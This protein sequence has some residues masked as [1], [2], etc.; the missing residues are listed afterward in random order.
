MC[1]RDRGRVARGIARGVVGGV[2]WARGCSGFKVPRLG[3][4]C[5]A[6]RRG[7]RQPGNGHECGRLITSMLTG[8]NASATQNWSSRP[9]AIAT[10]GAPRAVR[11]R[12]A[13]AVLP[14]AW[15][16]RRALCEVAQRFKFAVWWRIR[17]LIRARAFA[18]SGRSLPGG[19]SQCMRNN[20]E[21]CV[22]T[23]TC[24]GTRWHGTCL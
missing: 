1:I 18:R 14:G 16:V 9:A 6:A 11:A 22:R 3:A 8:V 21:F 4:R 5:C 10:G 13:A 23:S 15:L 24:R 7:P 12:G 17:A 20:W 2:E 19:E